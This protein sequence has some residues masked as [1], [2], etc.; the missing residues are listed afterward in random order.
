MTRVSAHLRNKMGNKICP[1]ERAGMLESPLRK[2]MTK[3]AKIV[4]PYISEGMTAL[5]L[6]CGT[7]VFALEMARQMSTGKIIAADIQQ[8][9]LD[10]LKNKIAGKTVEKRIELHKCTEQS[11]GIKEQVDFILAFYVMHE[12]PNQAALFEE[13]STIIKPNGKMLIV[14]PKFHVTKK[15]FE[16]MLLL[17]KLN[18]TI[19]QKSADFFNRMVTLVRS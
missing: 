4:K 12:I 3:P 14:E 7:G 10:I 1:V 15:K 11:I 9:M 18:W 13:L 5:D 6:G 19:Q 8:G 2:W 16:T 17:S